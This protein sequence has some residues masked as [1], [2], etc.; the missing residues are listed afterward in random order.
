MRTTQTIRLVSG[1]RSSNTC[2]IGELGNPGWRKT[3]FKLKDCNRPVERL[4]GSPRA[5]SSTYSTLTAGSCN[6]TFEKTQER[7]RNAKLIRA[8]VVP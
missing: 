1:L 7:A 5:L 3:E 8:F 2:P 6:E 4:H